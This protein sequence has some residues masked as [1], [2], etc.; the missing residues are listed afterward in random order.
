MLRVAPGIA[1]GQDEIEIRFVRASG[2]GGQ[3]VNKVATAAQL[4]FDVRRSPSLPTEVKERLIRLAG[5]RATDDGV[6]V[7]D[8]RRHRTQQRN[9]VEAVARLA[10]LIRRAAVPPKRR[11]KTRPTAASRRRRLESKRRRGQLKRLRGPVRE[12]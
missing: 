11:R 5:G 9:R 6:L 7:L 12:E 2:P 3:N 4:R 1:I 8:A 10:E